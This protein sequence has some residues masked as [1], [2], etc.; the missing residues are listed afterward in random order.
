VFIVQFAMSSNISYKHEDRQWDARINF[1]TDEYANDVIGAIKEEAD[2]GK[3]KYIL[4]G[5]YEIGTRSHQDD[6]G[7][8][9]V[10]IAAIFN[11]RCSK[12]T[13]TTSTTSMTT[14]TST[15]T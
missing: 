14:M 2:K 7:I 8:R 13:V 3:F 1:Q 10:H 11:N 9:H 4:I 5:G 12:G 6:Y 15:T